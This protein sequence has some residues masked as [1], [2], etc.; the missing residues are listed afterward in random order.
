MTAMRTWLLLC[1]A[2]LA[3]QVAHA[4]AT[5]DLPGLRSA[6]MGGAH[7]GLGTSNDALM[8]NPAGMALN[9]HYSFDAAYGLAPKD[10]VNR[11]S[12]TAV[13]SKTSP[14]AGG[15]GYTMDKGTDDNSDAAL[16]RFYLG[17][18]FPITPSLAI[19]TTGRYVRGDIPR[20][21]AAGRDISLFTGDLGI[22]ARIESLGFGFSYKNLI[23]TDDNALAKRAMGF[24]AAYGLGEYL[25]LAADISMTTENKRRLSYHLGAEYFL[26]G[27][28]PLRFGYERRPFAQR[29]GDVDNES[30]LCGGIGYT[31]DTGALEATYTQ[32]LER[33]NNW[34]AIAAIK[35]F[36]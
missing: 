22:A 10:G 3:T 26:L 36:L 2:S 24:G 19:G 16:H 23:R 31:A 30:I 17:L 14:V 5:D 20:A 32:S 9:Q 6:A 18:A 13:D 27:K 1:A 34:Q 12:F 21:G 4:D 29:N 15:A 11:L 33:Q 8:L 7:R 35:F 28:M 25:V